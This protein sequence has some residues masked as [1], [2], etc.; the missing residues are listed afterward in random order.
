M[1]LLQIIFTIVLVIALGYA[2]ARAVLAALRTVWNFLLVI[3]WG[4]I[5]IVAAT[6]ILHS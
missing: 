3:F 2:V 1:T 4:V 5:I 6:L